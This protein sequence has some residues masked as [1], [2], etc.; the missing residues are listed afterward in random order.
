MY[1]RS[2]ITSQKIASSLKEKYK[3]YASTANDSMVTSHRTLSLS[4]P[5]RFKAGSYVKTPSVINSRPRKG[6]GQQQGCFEKWENKRPQKRYKCEG[7]H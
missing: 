3:N 4:M 2:P 6:Q 1:L 7:C 5:Q